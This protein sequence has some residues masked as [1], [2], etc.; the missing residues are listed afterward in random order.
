MTQNNKFLLLGKVRRLMEKVNTV[1][2]VI[3]EAPITPDHPSIL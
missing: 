3:F 2:Q 1:I